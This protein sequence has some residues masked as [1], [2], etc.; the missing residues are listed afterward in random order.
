MFITVHVA[1]GAAIASL[2]P[3]PLVAVPLAFASHFVLDAIPHWHDILK[4]EEPT[5][6]TVK[7]AGTDLLVAIALTA[8][9]IFA[10]GNM[11]LSYGIVAGTIMDTD[12]VL[13]PLCENRGWRKLWPSFISKLHGGI[14]NETKSLWGVAPQV[15]IL[16]VALFVVFRNL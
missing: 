16:I 3:N 5:R 9:L 11:I 15:T 12:V 14:Q 1:T 13:Y 7:I 8:Y 2:V 6:R 4:S 10:A